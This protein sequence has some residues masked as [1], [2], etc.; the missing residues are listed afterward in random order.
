M[1]ARPARVL[2]CVMRIAARSRRGCTAPPVAVLSSLLAVAAAGC[3]APTSAHARHIDLY[4]MPPPEP[5]AAVDDDPAPSPTEPAATPAE[6]PPAAPAPIDVR[7]AS[8]RYDFAI[9]PRESYVPPDAGVDRAVP[10]AIVVL[11][12]GTKKEL[13]RMELDRVALAATRGPAA[14]LEATNTRW[15]GT[16]RVGDF[17]FDGHEDLAVQTTTAGDEAPTYQVFLYDARK[18]E[19]ELS[20][21]LSDL[22]SQPIYPSKT[23]S[24]PGFLV[25]DAG[26]RR[27][28]VHRKNGCCDP[29]TEQYAFVRGKLTLVASVEENAQDDHDVR[30]TT[31]ALEGNRY[32]TIDTVR[33]RTR[34]DPPLDPAERAAMAASRAGAEGPPEE[35]EAAAAEGPPDPSTPPPAPGHVP[36]PVDVRDASR[37]YDF[38]VVPKEECPDGQGRVPCPVAAELF[39]FRKGAHAELQHFALPELDLVTEPNGQLLTNATRLYDE[40]G[41][42]VVGD[43]DFDGHDDFAVQVGQDGP[44]GGPTFRVFLYQPGKGQ[45]VESDALS[46]LTQSHLG[47]FQVDTRRKR[48]IAFSKSGCCIHYTSEFAY[49]SGALVLVESLEENSLFGGGDVMTVIRGTLEG[50]KWC[51]VTT[52]RP[53]D[54]D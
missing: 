20:Q 33:P 46:E 39:V 23:A 52:T 7:D 25:L 51:E 11:R 2:S 4:A 27:I 54:G 34:E 22:T 45:F 24:R 41:T 37:Q 18:G 13:Q 19:F 26:A 53:V 31:G 5:V 36:P 15:P 28:V 6:P 32:C 10:A 14:P 49:R 3:G 9:L 16:L 12:K 47:F 21:D 40:Q 8:K 1:D 44:Y 35:A 48:L 17:N 50:N 30:I 42:L 29:S 38:R 43:F